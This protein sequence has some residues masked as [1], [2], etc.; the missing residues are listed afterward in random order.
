MIEQHLKQHGYSEHYKEIIEELLSQNN[1][2]L[3]KT[4]ASY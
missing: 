2:D 3:E 1:F 4:L